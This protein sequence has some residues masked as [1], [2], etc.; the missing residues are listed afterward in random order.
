MKTHV[1][2]AVAAISLSHFHNKKVNSVYDY[3]ERGYI[4]IDTSTDG[5]RVI[6]YDHTNGCHVDGNLPSLFHYGEGSHLDLNP[7]G[8]GKYLGYDY[9]SSFHFEIQVKG[10]S[11]E[12]YDYGSSGF[13]SYSL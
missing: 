12:V 11:A 3:G 4:N 2:A 6:G 9:G 7:K 13:Y 5:I 1:R 8:D 10:T